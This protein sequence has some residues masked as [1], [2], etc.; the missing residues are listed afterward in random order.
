MSDLSHEV[1]DEMLLLRGR[2]LF[3]VYDITRRLQSKCKTPI[4]HDEVRSTVEA[5]YRQA[6]LRRDIGYHLPFSPPPQIYY[7]TGQD[8]NDYDPDALDPANVNVT[9]AEAEVAT[10]P[11]PRTLQVVAVPVQTEYMY[12]LVNKKTGERIA[13]YKGNSIGLYKTRN[14]PSQLQDSRSLHRDYE[15]VRYEVILKPVGN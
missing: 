5:F 1:I 13:P 6:G 14:G 7:V 8:I 11:V 9:A 4:I 10:I 15:V 2:N 12:A 3:T